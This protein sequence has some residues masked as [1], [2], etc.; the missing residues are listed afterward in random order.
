VKYFRYLSDQNLSLGTTKNFTFYTRQPNV[1]V[2]FFFRDISA[3]SAEVLPQFCGLKGTV[4]RDLR[5][6]KS[7][8]SIGFPLSYQRFALDF[9][10]IRPPF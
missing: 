5:E 4:R 2:D 3:D 7:G 1:L 10:F 6:V 8:K 9:N